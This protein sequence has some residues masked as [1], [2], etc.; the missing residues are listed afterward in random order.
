ML[1]RRMMGAVLATA[2]VGTMVGTTGCC[3]GGADADLPASVPVYAGAQKKQRVSIMGVTAVKYQVSGSAAKVKAFYDSKLAGAWTPKDATWVLMGKIAGSTVE[4]RS[5]D[6]NGKKGRLLV[7]LTTVP[8]GP[9]TQVE[10]KYC[11]NGPTGC[12]PK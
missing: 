1:T 12:Q 10:L 8:I 9:R 3:K 4:H 11:A 6:E 5:F 7:K 2:V